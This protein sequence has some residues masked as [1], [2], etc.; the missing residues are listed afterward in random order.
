[1]SRSDP[2]ALSGAHLDKGLVRR[3]WAFA[4]AYRGRTFLFLGVIVAEAV[5]GLAT[6]LL[7]RTIVDDALPQT[8]GGTADTT[9]LTWCAAG[10]AGAALAIAGLSLWERLLSSKIGEGLI[11]DLRVALFDH[12]QRMPVAFFTRTQTGA[13][14]SRMNNDVIGAQRAVTQTLGSVVSNVVVLATTLTA[15]FVLEWRLTLLS[16]LLLPVFVIPAKRVGRKLQTITRESFD[17]NASMNTTMTERFNVSG[18]TL[19]KLF[20]RTGDET[21][22]FTERAGRVRDIGV[23]SAMY[24]RTFLTALTLVGAM[25][26]AVI[27]LVGGR[28]VI[29]GS[30]SLGTLVALGTFVVQIYAPLTQLTNARVDLMTAFVSFDRVFEVLDAPRAITDRPGAVDLVDPEGRIELDGVRF[31]YP[32]AAEVSIA[33]LEAEAGMPLDADASTEILHG[34]DVTVEPGQ[35]VALVGPSGAGKSTLVSL[36]PRLYDVTEGALRIDGTDVRDLTQESLRAAIGVVSQD[37]HLFHEGIAAN[38][39]YAK[40]DATDDE[41]VAACRAARIHDSIAALPDGYDTIVGERGYRMSGGEKQRLAIARML[42]KDPRI[43]VLDEATSHLDTENEAAVQA[44]LA[45]ALAGRT[46]VVI[47]HRLSTIVDADQIL[48]L[49]HGDVV[50][51]GRHA[52]LLAADGLYA[53]LYR[54]LL[55][56]EDPAATPG[57]DADGDDVALHPAGRA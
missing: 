13:L 22:G 25:G 43:V 36:I 7:I 29:S 31:R 3:V 23:R 12:V 47:A 50:E 26:T 37:P 56:G 16:L 57:P 33:S 39:R 54:A 51:R 41:L 32:A 18:A 44:A 17:L 21:A 4:H 1:M 40:P 8:D 38:L 5:L 24:S 6:P 48:V 49:D 27:Y 28:L 10:M 55:R 20:G 35:T 53:E 34:L 2:S 46:A 15:M 14:I 11:Y 9:L 19:V 42:L 45:E 30:I 52:S